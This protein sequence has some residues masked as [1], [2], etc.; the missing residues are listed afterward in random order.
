MNNRR[1]FIFSRLVVTDII[2]FAGIV[3]ACVIFLT[4]S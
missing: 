1:S 3:V 4:G 2:A